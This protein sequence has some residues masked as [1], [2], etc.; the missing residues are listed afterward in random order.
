MLQARFNYDILRAFS[1]L[2]PIS[3]ATLSARLPPDTPSRSTH[4]GRHTRCFRHLLVWKANQDNFRWSLPTIGK[5]VLQHYLPAVERLSPFW[6]SERSDVMRVLVEE[7]APSAGAGL[8][9]RSL[10]GVGA[11]L[12]ECASARHPFGGS[13]WRRRHS[14]GQVPRA[15]EW[16]SGGGGRPAAVE[17]RSHSLG[18]TSFAQDLVALRSTDVLVL[19]H[20]S[21]EMNAV[22]MPYHSSLVEVR[23]LNADNYYANRWHPQISLASSFGY[24]WWG[25][26]VQDPG[27][28]QPSRLETEGGLYNDSDWRSIA[29]RKRDQDVRLLWRHLHV[30]LTE[31]ARVG[32]SKEQ[33]AALFGRGLE[34]HFATTAFEALPSGLVRRHRGLA[35]GAIRERPG[36]IEERLSQQSGEAEGEAL[37]RALEVSELWPIAEVNASLEGRASRDRT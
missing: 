18:A 21:A 10:L 32:R 4:E 25:L 34:H 13:S 33:Y 22:F 14:L 8:P 17:C 30:V 15:D 20:G 35:K 24:L 12:A 11:L 16:R 5:A 7:R 27:L 29:Y 6:R 31:V 1:S 28:A 23:G 36:A 9:T 3:F 26:L 2:E 37:R 19:T